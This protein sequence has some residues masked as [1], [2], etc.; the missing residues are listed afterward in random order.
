MTSS[1]FDH[2]RLTRIDDWMQSYIDHGRY[3]G[4][5]VLVTEGGSVVH[6]A[7]S[8][9]RDVEAQTPFTEDTITRI[10]SMTKP[11]A[12]VVLMTFVE[13]G[14]FHLD[15][16]VS[17]FIPEF[18][19]ARALIPGAASVDQTE[20]CPV[21]TLVQLLT[22][23]SGLTYG[24]NPGLL[25]E[26]YVAEKIAF[27]GTGEGLASATKRI[28]ALPLAFQPGAK[29]EYSHATDVIGRV[30]EVV[31]GKPLDQVFKEEVFAPLGMKDT[32]FQIPEDRLD[33]LA[34]LYTAQDGNSFGLGLKGQDQMF[35]I[36][37]PQ[38]SAWRDVKT[39]SGGGGLL[40]TI[41]DYFQ[42]TEMLRKGGAHNG[43]RILSPATMRFMM[44]NFLPGD[45]AS[46]GTKSFAEM[47]MD[48]IGFGLAGSV[49]IDPA[50]C[51]MPG[52]VGDFSWGGIAST[53]FW[54]D[55]V[56]DISC[57]FLTQ[58]TPSSSYPSRPQLKA[59]VHGAMS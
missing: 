19:D 4:A 9:Y 41:D 36:D 48:G 1:A 56:A 45:I 39:Y 12:S 29:W 32:F 3:P 5:T 2:D 16:P 42:F 38:T 6:R 10:Y 35:L 15:T 7:T 17:E 31:A 11:I 57:I 8:G 34:S 13:Q 53:F 21:P 40:S 54:I 22:H 46:M 30:I 55:P 23:T 44:R 24:F 18:A 59:L 50:R 25:P 37:A 51:G 58:L 28:A 43:A 33:R 49:V 47:P 27:S 14:L 26:L 20:P 52:N